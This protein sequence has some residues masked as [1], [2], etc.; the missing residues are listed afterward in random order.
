MKTTAWDRMRTGH[1]DGIWLI[2]YSDMMT[3]LLTFF[4]TLLSVAKVQRHRFEL[5][6]AALSD[7]KTGSPLAE[8]ERR[9]ETWVREAKLDDRVLV[10]L[11]PDGL[12]VQLTNALLF[13]SGQA[14]LTPEGTAI[15]DRLLGMLS[16]VDRGYRLTVEGYSDDVPI[17]NAAFRSN[18][19]LSSQRAIEVVHRMV[20]RGISQ[21]R[22][23]IQGFADTRPV[24]P[25]RVPEGLSADAQRLYVRTLNRRVVI[26]VNR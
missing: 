8:L 14:R 6:S 23:S 18:W 1:D 11:G 12:R 20:D 24:R 4:V 7:R 16:T 5:M 17:S 9:V 3:L 19:E 10:D 13:E 26:V 2:S 21:D 25:A 15:V 22:L